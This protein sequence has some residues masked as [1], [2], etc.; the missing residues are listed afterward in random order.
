[1]RDAGDDVLHGG[2]GNDI[3]VGGTGRDSAS[4]DGKSTDYKVTHDASGWHVADQRSGGTDGTD[5]LQD[6]ERVTFA[7]ATVA[8]D[9]DGAAGQAYRFYRAAFD[10]TPDLPGLG[11]WIGA[12]DK[13]SSVQDL[14]AGF[15]ASKEFTTMYGGASNADIVGRLYHNVLHRTPEQAGYDYWLHVLDNKQA[16]LSD[17]LAA[18][19]ES[20]GNKDA[21]ADLIANGILFTP[22]QG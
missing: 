12:M 17:V 18:F 6:V 14:A 5:T 3:L 1:M 22:W 2:A 13:G 10:R 9:T 16:S 11:F 4:Y 19:S 20:A 7:D 8:L 15:S 21:V